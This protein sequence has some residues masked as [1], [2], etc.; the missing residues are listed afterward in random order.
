VSKR[1]LSEA[2]KNLT[3]FKLLNGDAG[4]FPKWKTLK[5][6]SCSFTM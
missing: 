3:D 2:L 1:H 5:Y 6:V 4:I